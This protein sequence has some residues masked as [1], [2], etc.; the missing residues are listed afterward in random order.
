[1]ARFCMLIQL[2]TKAMEEG[3]MRPIIILCCFEIC[4][5]KMFAQPSK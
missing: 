1:M 3:Y 2:V 4:L 5:L